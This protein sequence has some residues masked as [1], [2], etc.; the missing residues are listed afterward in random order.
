MFS[1]PEGR[2]ANQPF[3]ATTLS[4]PI[5]A[6]LAGARVSLA[7]IGSPARSG[8]L[9]VGWI[10]L[11]RAALFCSGVAGGIDARVEGR[12]ELGGELLVMLT[13]VLAGAGEDL[14]GEQVEDRA[15]LVG[16]PDG[17]VA[18]KEAGAGALLAAEAER[19]V[20][21]PGANHLKPTGT[22]ASGRSR[23][24]HDPVDQAAADQGLAHLGMRRPVR[25]DG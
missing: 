7:M 10:E 16:R 15:V 19:A 9:D 25:R 8:S 22:S 20:E 1:V 2:A 6:S 14:R 18:T 13:R 4:P 12:A 3:E 17:A 24:L 21:Q 11:L 5:G 23:L